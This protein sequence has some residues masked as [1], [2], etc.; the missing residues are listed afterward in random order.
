[1][2]RHFTTTVFVLHEGQ[3]LLMRHPKLRNGSPWGHVEADELPTDAAIREA[4]EETGLDVE[5]VS[6]ENLWIDR[7][8]AQS[9]PRPY[10]CQ[11]VEM[12]AHGNDPAHQHMDLVYVAR[13]VGGIPSEGIRWF[14]LA[15]IEELQSGVDIFE[16]TKQTLRTLLS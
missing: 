13:P 5:L 15:E 1:M 16:E 14:T 11:L 9:F 10:L 8:N 3:A 2:M 6:Q 4:R 12:P 7:P